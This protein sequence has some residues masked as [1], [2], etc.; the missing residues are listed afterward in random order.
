[1]LNFSQSAVIKEG[2]RYASPA[3]S[4]TPRLVP[5]GGARLPDGRFLPAGTRVGM[6][7]YHVHYNSTIF[8]NPRVFDPDRWLKPAAEIEKQ[9]KF[10]V[11]FS[12]GNRACAGIKYV[13]HFLGRSQSFARR[14]RTLRLKHC[15]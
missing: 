3:A 12:R 5:T 4:R 11:A 8:S 7:I 13:L 9:N 15:S 6:A 10:M 2:L 1:M 14:H